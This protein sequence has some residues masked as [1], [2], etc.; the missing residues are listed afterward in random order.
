MRTAV[1]SDINALAMKIKPELL[2]TLAGLS[3]QR[4]AEVLDFARFL[5]QRVG[6][7]I[8]AAIPVEL[9]PA[10]PETLLRLM[11][12]VALGGDALADSEALYDDDGSC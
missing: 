10:P 1:H 2:R 5:E 4:Q 8:P 3:Q 12:V 9:R 6:R 7:H 11:G